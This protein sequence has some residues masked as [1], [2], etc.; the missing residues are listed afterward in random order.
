MENQA[1]VFPGINQAELVNVEMPEAGPG[2]VVV[3][4]VISSVSSGTERALITG[5]TNTNPYA[6]VVAEKPKFPR[7]P[8]YSAAGVIHAVGEGVTSVKPGDRVAIIDTAHRRFEATKEKNVFKIGDDVSFNEAALWHIATF[9]LAAVR[10]CNLE[11]GESAIVM[12]LGVLGMMAVKL[13][14]CGG[15]T[16]IIAVDP[17][18]EKRE[19][20]L[21][22]GADYALDPFDPEFA[23]TAKNLTNGGAKV[24]IEVTGIGAGLNGI[25]DCMAPFGRVAL[26]GC[27]R[28]SD[29][30]VDYYRKVHGPGITLVGAHT[31][32]RPKVESYHGMWTR[33]DDVKALRALHESGRLEF[34]S[35][36]AEVHPIEEA[37]AVYQRLATEKFFPVV[38]HSW[39]E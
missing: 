4:T 25:L 10:K 37:P 14:R 16:P 9:P 13:L 32:A 8:G 28:R 20:A 5:E 21:K 27:T 15:A 7:W 19:W 3:R 29:F 12:G 1:V 18:A 26:L 35:M 2:E 17:V 30:T 39:G 11:M 6:A 36:I 23:A 34:A 24:G 31:N 22:N 33:W 38:Q